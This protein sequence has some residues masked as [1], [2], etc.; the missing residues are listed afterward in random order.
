LINEEINRPILTSSSIISN[1]YGAVLINGRSSN[2]Y[3]TVAIK[4]KNNGKSTATIQ[5]IDPNVRFVSS[6]T[7]EKCK[8]KRSNIQFI[9]SND[10]TEILSGMEKEFSRFVEV[11]PECDNQTVLI[12]LEPRVTYSD[13]SSGTQYQ[14]VFSAIVEVSLRDL[15]KVGADNEQEKK[16][17]Q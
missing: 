9:N 6:E 2:I 15:K 11:T 12:S 14:Q 10:A 13:K 4:L 7:D 1:G 5:E 17:D 8:L 16:L 3:I